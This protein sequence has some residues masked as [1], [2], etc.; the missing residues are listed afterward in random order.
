MPRPPLSLEEQLA[1]GAR[2]GELL[3]DYDRLARAAGSREFSA[4]LWLSL[5]PT[6]FINGLAWALLLISALSPGGPLLVWLAL[7]FWLA[8]QRSRFELLGREAAICDYFTEAN[9]DWAEL[10][11]NLLEGRRVPL[12]QGNAVHPGLQTAASGDELVSVDTAS[13]ESASTPLP[14]VLDSQR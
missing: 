12:A 5:L 9:Q 8:C 1:E 13:V 2:L 10:L 3:V 6:P 4:R 7:P 11:V 14:P